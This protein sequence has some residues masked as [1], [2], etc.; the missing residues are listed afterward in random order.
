MMVRKAT[1]NVQS[2]T[3]ENGVGGGHVP[4][5][6]HGGSESS[7]S[8]SVVRTLKQIPKISLDAECFVQSGLVWF[9]GMSEFRVKKGL[10]QITGALEDIVEA[11]EKH[12]D[13]NTFG[14]N[15][16]QLVPMFDNGCHPVSSYM[17]RFRTGNG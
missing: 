1:G 14:K 6:V 7:K 5:A 3:F 15:S 2:R 8:Y 11:I 13:V 9:V 16:E 12:Q 4:Q 17:L 10:G